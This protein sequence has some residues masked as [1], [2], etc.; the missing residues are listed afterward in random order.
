MEKEKNGAENVRA[1]ERA[2]D[3]LS[4]FGP[5]DGELTVVDLLK[6]VDLSRATL[7]RLLYTLEQTGFVSA[8]GDPQRFRLGPA[9]G[10]LAWAWS[11]SQNLAQRALPVMQSVWNA[12]GETVA[13]F[14]PQG[15]MRVCVAELPSP[16]PL[17][18]KRGVGYTE[19]IVRGASG[20]AVLAWQDLKP[21]ELAW[22]CEG[23]TITPEQLQT[24]LAEV[25]RNG[26]AVSQDELIMGAAAVA[27]PF[28]DHTSQVAGSLAVFGPMVRLNGARITEVTQL[29][30]DAAKT[31][32]ATLGGSPAVQQ[33]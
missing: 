30:L 22:L 19:R 17:S 25:R 12:T 23:E 9:V 2:L 18:F 5:G 31:L 29:V 6:R 3:I 33:P 28:F 15:K 1:V 11:A 13:L 27:V 14:A 8:E 20:R 26:Y 32:T 10:R 7:Y 21:D 4:A 16:H 24:Q